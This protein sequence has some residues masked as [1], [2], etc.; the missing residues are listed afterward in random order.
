MMP[1]KELSRLT[2]L[3]LRNSS[4]SGSGAKWGSSAKIMHCLVLQ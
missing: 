2:V 3:T 1:V 4:S